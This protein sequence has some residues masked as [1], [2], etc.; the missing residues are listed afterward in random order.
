MLHDPAPS[1]EMSEEEWLRWRLEHRRVNPDSYLRLGAYR[2]GM[3][4]CGLAVPDEWVRY[5]LP[6]RA[7]LLKL[8]EELLAL[9]EGERPEAVIAHHASMVDPLMEVFAARGIEL[10][11]EGAV[12]FPRPFLFVWQL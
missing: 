2:Q 11:G 1:E 5:A 10:R 8:G 7:E 12:P 9:P 3:D 6:G 4:E